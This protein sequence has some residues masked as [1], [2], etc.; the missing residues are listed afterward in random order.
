MSKGLDTYIS[1]YDNI[2]LLGDLS[3]ETS[4]PVLN[5]VELAETFNTFFSKIAPNLNVDNNLA[6]NRTNPN[7]TDPVFCAI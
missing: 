2:M 3:V 1:Q 6:D 5:D 7:I 4:D